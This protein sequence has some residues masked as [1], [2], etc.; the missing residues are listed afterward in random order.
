MGKLDDL[1]KSSRGI[2]SESMGRPATVPMNGSSTHAAA[3]EIPLAK[4]SPDPA[5]PREDFDAAALS[6]LAESMKAR[7][8]LQ[9]IQVRWDD[10][11]GR[12]VIV[13]GERRW[14][15]AEQ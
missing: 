9:P 4:I 3:T 6:R 2:A 12:Y 7:G 5:Q 13:C 11:A 15:A 1:M 8:P 10:G 14:T